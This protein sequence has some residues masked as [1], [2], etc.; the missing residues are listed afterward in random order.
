MG[1]P[2][3]NAIDMWSLGCILAELHTTKPLFPARDEHE[4]L[5]RMKYTVGMPP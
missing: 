1:V 5:E 3:T 2:Y 4:L